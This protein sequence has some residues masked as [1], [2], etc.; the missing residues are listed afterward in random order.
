MGK[1]EMKEERMKILDLLSK[2]LISADEA[3]K[4]LGAIGKAEVE[5]EETVNVI[6]KKKNQFKMLKILVDS[7]GGDKVRVELPIEFAKLLKNKKFGNFDSSD[8]D[9]DIDMLLQMI[10]TGVVGEIVNVESADGDIVK[11][12]V[13]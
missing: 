13:E 10:N 9:I 8:F 6:S 12:I 1:H 2:G 11:I 4:L 5:V 3:E 7:V